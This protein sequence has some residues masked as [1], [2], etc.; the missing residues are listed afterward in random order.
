METAGKDDEMGNLYAIIYVEDEKL[1][2]SRLNDDN[3]EDFIKQYKPLW[4]G[5]IDEFEDALSQLMRQDW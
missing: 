4:Y 2:F 5:N 3:L 1:H